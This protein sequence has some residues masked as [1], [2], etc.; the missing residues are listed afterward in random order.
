MR[1]CVVYPPDFA[2]A[3]SPSTASANTSAAYRSWGSRRPVG[4]GGAEA[5]PRAVLDAGF[6]PA[7]DLGGDLEVA[8]EHP[9]R[10]GPHVERPRRVLP[11]RTRGLVLT[12]RPRRDARVA[13]A[14]P[15]PRA[16]AFKQRPLDRRILRSRGRRSGPS[17]ATESRPDRTAASVAGNDSSCAAT[18]IA[19]F[20]SPELD[21][22]QPLRRA[23]RQLRS[24]P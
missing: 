20:A 4:P 3:G 16:A 6:D 23:P 24:V 18:E 10:C 17:A 11:S 14:A 22:D 7:A 8:F 19:R 13:Q 1:T 2:V 12:P 9:V 5:P 21:P 15:Y